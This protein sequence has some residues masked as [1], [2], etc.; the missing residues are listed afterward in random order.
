MAIL[1]AAMRHCCILDWF[2]GVH[3]AIYIY[4]TM[5]MIYAHK[6]VQKGHKRKER[7]YGYSMGRRIFGWLL[8]ATNHKRE[9]KDGMCGWG[10]LLA[11]ACFQALMTMM[12]WFLGI[13]SIQCLCCLL[14]LLWISCLFGHIWFFTKWRLL[15]W[16]MWWWVYQ[17]QAPIQSY[18][19][20]HSIMGVTRAAWGLSWLPLYYYTRVKNMPHQSMMR[21]NIWW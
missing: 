2:G 21:G 6:W 7:P 18:D 3:S 9:G 19:T 5:C 1:K 20:Y 4:H 8:I 16:Y 17:Q 15:G 13:S 10:A 12:H 14:L 11:S